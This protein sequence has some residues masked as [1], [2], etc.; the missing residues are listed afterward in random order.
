MFKDTVFLPAQPGSSAHY[1]LYKELNLDKS[2]T[3]IYLNALYIFR[4]NN[5]AAH[6]TALGRIKDL[7]H[8]QP[9]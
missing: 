1:A 2:L 3:F 8:V 7:L 4:E 9:S 5:S 6:L